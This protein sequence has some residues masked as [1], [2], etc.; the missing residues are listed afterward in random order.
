MLRDEEIAELLGKARTIAMVGASDRP[1]R[2]SNGVMKF[3]QGHGCR[4]LPVNPNITGERIHGD[5]EGEDHGAVRVQA[6]ERRWPAGRPVRHGRILGGQVRGHELADQSAD[7][8]PRQSRTHDQLR[9]GQRTIGMELADD[10]AQVGASNRLAALSDVVAAH[11]HEVCVPLFQKPWGARLRH[12]RCPCQAVLWRSR[13][14]S[15]ASA[16]IR[17]CRWMRSTERGGRL[18]QAGSQ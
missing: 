8:G 11:P 15:K 5:L 9:P 3:L 16:T 7:R 4:V 18:S 12:A 17:A 10:R 1:D 14:P 6:N 13:S 2:P